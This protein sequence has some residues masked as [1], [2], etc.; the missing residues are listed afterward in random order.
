VYSAAANVNFVV[1]TMAVTRHR[2]NVHALFRTGPAPA[3]ATQI[4]LTLLRNFPLWPENFAHSGDRV[5]VTKKFAIS[6]RG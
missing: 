2:R 3:K 1:C 5:M 6:R 4:L